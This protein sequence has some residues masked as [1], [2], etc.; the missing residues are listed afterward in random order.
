[1]PVLTRFNRTIVELKSR[2]VY[3]CLLDH[4]GFNRTIVELKLLN[5]FVSRHARGCFNRTIVELK[6]KSLVC[7]ICPKAPF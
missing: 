5:C 7:V 3:E 2:N 6:S 1:M 4:L